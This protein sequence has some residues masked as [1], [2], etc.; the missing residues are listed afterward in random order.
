VWVSLAVTAMVILV[1]ALPLALVVRSVA[2]SRAIGEA[3]LQAAAAAS[4]L[5][6]TDHDAV[7]KALRSTDVGERRQILVHMPDGVRLGPGAGWVDEARVEETRKRRRPVTVPVTGGV[8]HL[9]PVPLRD[10][11]VAVIEVFVPDEALT[12]HV[13]TAWI[14]LGGL[15]IAMLVASALLADRLAAGAVRA[16]ER[17]A[18]A[19]TL[20]GDGDLGVRV[21][22]SG[23]PEIA[24][25]G[26]AFNNLADR[27]QVLLATERELV[28]DLS[29]RLRTPLTALR[30]NTEALPAGEPRHRVL[31]AAVNLEREVDAI[32]QQAR[33][34]LAARR[35]ARCELVDVVRERMRTWSALADDQ[36]RRW[37][38]DAPNA[39]IW[40][41]VSESDVAA[42]VDAIVGN[43]FRHTPEGTPYQVRIR[44]GRGFVMLSVDDGGPGIA[45]PAKALRR[46]ASGGASTGLG[47]DI[48]RRVA[49]DA[50][51]GI[52]I[53]SGRLGGA[54]VTLTL[55]VVGK[56]LPTADPV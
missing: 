34:P 10:E 46:G 9:R 20:L 48:A 5:C 8:A 52:D 24:T 21:Q 2:A 55:R 50:G 43:V 27:F 36:G 22:P 49:E 12:R 15:G 11:S 28:A 40:V 19:A 30:L 53:G 51:G 44:L 1:F 37:E 42:A 29:H 38:F 31:T 47:T 23:P 39:P 4:V 25:V 41:P 26:R 17:L 14:V 35:P 56:D 33:R 3:E 13:V 7:D 6:T 18:G 16:T 54:R 32:I 45:E